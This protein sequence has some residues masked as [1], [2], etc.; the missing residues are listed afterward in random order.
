MK[1]KKGVSVI[2]P[3]YNAEKF[4]EKCIATL[5]LQSLEDIDYIFIIDKN[6][7]DSSLQILNKLTQNMNNIQIVS[8]TLGSGLGY[9]R[10]IGLKY[11]EREYIG[12]IDADDCISKN[13]YEK[14]YSYAKK[15][16]AD[17]AMSNTIVISDKKELYYYT[18]NNFKIIDNISDMYVNMP[19]SSVWNKI[20]KTEL[21]Q[22]NSLIRF[23]EG[24]FHEDN[25][26]TLY[27]LYYTNKLLLVPDVN[28]FWIRNN[29]SIT[30]NPKNKQK[31]ITDGKIVFETI[32]KIVSEL[33][34]S[35]KE[36]Y[37]VIQHNINCYAKYILQEKK[38]SDILYEQ[39]IKIIGEDYTNIIRSNL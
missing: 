9:N 10:N 33:N 37:T 38:Y 21:I 26:F 35:Q 25:L 6:T 28:Y 1:L 27:A 32:L 19:Y 17:I 14:L 36:K 30:Q 8:P 22:N 3:V 12:Y 11:V 29:N 39:I 16:N 18:N 15:Y 7:T 23:M 4:I 24:V 5:T 2:I 31:I 20:Y 13:F 34:M